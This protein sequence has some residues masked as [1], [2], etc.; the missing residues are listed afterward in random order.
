M[1]KALLTFSNGETLELQ[2]E[3]YIVPIVKFPEEDSN[4]LGVSLDKPYQLW[5][6]VRGG[7]IPSICEFL[8]NCEFFFLPDNR[9]KIYNSNAVVTIKNL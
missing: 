3:Q 6:H 4:R 5:S 8:C 9:E 2:D 1:V 7:L